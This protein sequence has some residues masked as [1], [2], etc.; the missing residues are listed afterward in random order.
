MVAFLIV[1]HRNLFSQQPY[2][3]LSEDLSESKNLR[4]ID[5]LCR[6]SVRRSFDVLRLLR[7][8]AGTDRHR[9]KRP[10]NDGWQTRTVREAG[11][12]S[13]SPQDC[14]ACVRTGS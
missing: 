2:V 10:R 14:Y 11:P 5:V 13:R 8:T 12:Y 9:R 3:I 1:Y 4:S 6:N 7:M